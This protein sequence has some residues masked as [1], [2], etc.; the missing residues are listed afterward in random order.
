MGNHVKVEYME[1]E[2][3]SNIGLELAGIQK[4]SL[5]C[6]QREEHS[7]VVFSLKITKSILVQQLYQLPIQVD[8]PGALD[9]LKIHTN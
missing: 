1:I 2:S 6:W 9:Y 4:F 5:M 3:K 7:C 8:L